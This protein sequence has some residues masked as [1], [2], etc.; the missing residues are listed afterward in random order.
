MTMSKKNI[1][2]IKSFF[3]AIKGLFK[4]FLNERNLRIHLCACTY[5]IWISGFYDFST[6]EKAL[7]AVVIGF[8]IATEILNTAIENLV[9]LVSPKYDVRAGIVKDI[10]AG[11]VLISAIT[12]IAVA[13]IMFFD[14]AILKNVFFSITDKLSNILLFISSVFLWIAIIFYKK[15]DKKRNEN[16]EN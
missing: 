11:G 10:A 8:V 3:C 15:N 2:L 1:P 13:F 12:A 7:I 14:I 4:C 16:N 9:D 6:G 5:V